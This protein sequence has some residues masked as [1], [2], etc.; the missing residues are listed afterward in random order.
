M[1]NNAET[2]KQAIALK[3]EGRYD[4]AILLLKNAICGDDSCLDE[5]HR[6]LGLVYSFSGLF[7]ESLE[8]LK[9]AIELNSNN[10]D[11]RNDLAMTYAMLGMYDEAKAEFMAVLQMD[12][13]NEQARKQMVYF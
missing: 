6:Q 2:L 1:G 8:E 13:E 3:I 7:D 4:E 11:A 5:A 10:L 12:P 9:K